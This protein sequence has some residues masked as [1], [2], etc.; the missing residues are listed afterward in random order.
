MPGAVHENSDLLHISKSQE[1]NSYGSKI[2]ETLGILAK[3][4]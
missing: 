3:K 4:I 2:H 1:H